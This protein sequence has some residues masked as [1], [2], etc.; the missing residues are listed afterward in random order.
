MDAKRRAVQFIAKRLNPSFDPDTSRIEANIR[1]LRVID[2][3]RTAD[4]E[5]VMV[6]TSVPLS[7]IKIEVAFSP[8]RARRTAM[9]AFKE[10]NFSYASSLFSQLS[11][12]GLNDV[13]LVEYAR[14]AGWQVNLQAGAKGNARSQAESGLASFYLAR[15]EHE[16]ALQIQ[17]AIY[18]RSELPSEELLASLA[19]LS[20]A[21]ERQSSAEAFEAEAR[22]RYPDI[23]IEIDAGFEWIVG[24][25]LGR[26]E[27]AEIL[28]HGDRS[29]FVAVGSAPAS[30]EGAAAVMAQRQV[31]TAHAYREAAAFVGGAQVATRDAVSTEYTVSDGDSGRRVTSDR[32]VSS[33]IRSR[34]RTQLANLK[35][36]GAWR[37]DDKSVL[38]R[39]LVAEV[40]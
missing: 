5:G 30:G 19:D 31:A 1:G 14:A 36:V 12:K 35:P 2:T 7:G 6:I 34:A 38:F 15:K 21:T 9:R 4:G 23:S 13:V 10:G 20:R 39:A 17:Y 11:Q 22:R 24:T 32:S 28:S 29:Y 18:R 33:E 8:A 37:S 26:R 16:K 3:I 25:G 40:P 27:G